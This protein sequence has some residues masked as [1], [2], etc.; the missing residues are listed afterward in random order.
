MEKIG[1]LIS[2][3]VAFIIFLVVFSIF[4]LLVGKFA[5]HGKKNIEK[6]S[7]YACGENMP[8]FKFQ[9]GYNLFFIFALLF[10]M[11]HVAALVIAT[12]PSVSPAVYF[13]IFYLA[14]I[15]LSVMGVVFYDDKDSE[16]LSG[17]EEKG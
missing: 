10:T 6:Q 11:M 5:P 4:Y 9:F 7:T 8:G 14:A 16:S 3:P 13:G 17:M 2:P 12:L 15:F 1:I